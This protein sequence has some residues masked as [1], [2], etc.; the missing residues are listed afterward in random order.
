MFLMIPNRLIPITCAISMSRLSTDKSPASICVNTIGNT[1]RKDMKDG[2]T[3]L[4]TQSQA[5]IINAATGTERIRCI[6]GAIS[7]LKNDT[8]PD[9]IPR[10][11][12]IMSADRNPAA[13]CQSDVPTATQNFISFAD[14]N[15]ATIVSYGNGIF[16]NKFLFAILPAVCQSKIQNTTAAVP[17]S[18]FFNL[19][20]IIEIIS[21]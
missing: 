2:K 18:T 12:P 3:A 21:R 15:N 16:S 6:M 20:A 10:T 13:M 17:Y 5:R 4:G 14:S 19:T 8:F 7:V 1:I 11:L 9:N